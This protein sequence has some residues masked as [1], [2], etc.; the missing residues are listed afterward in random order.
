LLTQGDIPTEF[1][2]RAAALAGAPDVLYDGGSAVAAPDGTWVIEPVS[3]DERLVIAEIDPARVRGERQNFDPA[4]HY[5]R[6]DVF[7]VTVDR[8][9]REAAEFVDE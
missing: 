1:P 5:F 2:L 6:S 7:G 9:A 3:E 4:G 8:T